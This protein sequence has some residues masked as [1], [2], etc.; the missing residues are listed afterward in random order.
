MQLPTY[1]YHLAEAANWPSIQQH[2]LLSAVALFELAGL[3]KDERDRREQRYRPDHT[4]LPGGIQ[5]RDQKPM[6]A[7]IL[8]RC[9]VGLTTAQWYG[10]INRKVFFWLDPDRLDRQRNACGAR[11]QMVLVVHSERLLSRHA[12]RVGLSPINT[13]N[14]RR[15]PA[16]RGRSTFV[17][18]K[19]WLKSGWSSEAAGLGTRER[20][21][22]HRPVELTVEFAVR[23]IAEYI[24]SIQRLESGERWLPPPNNML[25][26]HR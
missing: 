11:P 6:P 3:P 18:Y 4:E 8:E 14:A 20:A 16:V 23:D 10:L 22:N 5:I 9:L 15:N 21:K 12:E 2:G 17:S 24:V 26:R 1:I 19:Q 13:G 7:Q 25:Q